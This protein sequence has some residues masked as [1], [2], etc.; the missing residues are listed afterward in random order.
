MLI[1]LALGS[2][3]LAGAFQL[4]RAFSR[5][6]AREEMIAE[7]QQSLRVS[8]QTMERM[9]RAAGSGLP[10]GPIPVTNCSGGTTN[11]YAIQ[12]S[13][14]NAIAPSATVFDP[15]NTFD[16][17][18][19]DADQDPDWIRIISG[20]PSSVEG[21]AGDSGAGLQVTEAGNFAVGDQFAIVDTATSPA[22]VCV[23]EVTGITGAHG[24]SLKHS[25]GA[26]CVNPGTDTCLNAVQAGNHWP[27]LVR[28][29]TGSSVVFRVDNTTNP[30]TP[31]LQVSF[32]P[33]D[34]PADAP[35]SWQTL[36]QNI[37]DL[38]VALVMDD[39]RVCGAAG[40][41]VDDP[42]LCDPTKVKAVRFTLTARSSS[43]VVGTL[44]D[45]PGGGYADVAATVY[46]QAGGDSYLRRTITTEVQLRN[47]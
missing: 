36:A 2:I 21:A 28:R 5:Q 31:Q 29:L 16:A 38:Q 6:S 24:G 45:R 19:Q 35:R 34:L 27:V 41:S 17:N 32:S 11:Y 22:T 42:A 7:M 33:I 3:V 26:S 9:I 43:P 30:A 40:Y 8:R 23:R 4:Q 44:A 13:N 15:K 47:Q 10:A 12:Y 18:P 37:E 46:T 20:P 39:G 25:G 1:S 14:S